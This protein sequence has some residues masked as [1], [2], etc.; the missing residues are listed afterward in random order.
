MKRQSGAVTIFLVLILMA[1]VFFAGVFIDA[2]RILAAKHELKNAAYAAARSTISYYDKNLVGEYGL[3]AYDSSAAQ[4]NF[5]K[6][7][8]ANIKTRDK[9]V[10][11]LNYTVKNITV[12]PGS[13]INDLEVF[14]DQVAEYSKYR[15]PVTTTM[16]VVDK[17]RSIF[18]L[19]DKADKITEAGDDLE[20]FKSKFKNLGHKAS[21]AVSSAAYNITSDVIDWDNISDSKSTIDGLMNNL[22]GSY[23]TAIA[24]MESAKTEANNY[25]QSVEQQMNAV[26]QGAGLGDIQQDADVASDAKEL[27]Q[28]GVV[29]VE[30]YARDEAQKVI[31]DA[32]SKKARAQT[33]K[34]E[35]TN[36][37][38]TYEQKQWELLEARNKYEDA[39]DTTEEK[40]ET[41]NNIKS[42][43][44]LEREIKI[45]EVRKQQLA[46]DITEKQAN[47][48][49][50]EKKKVDEYFNTG[51]YVGDDIF[52]ESETFI[53]VLELIDSLKD[54][55][56]EKN[57][58]VYANTQYNLHKDTAKAEYDVAKA[59]E[60][61]AKQAVEDIENELDS[62]KGQ[63]EG[64]LNEMKGLTISEP[65]EIKEKDA[66][67]GKIDKILEGEGEE[68]E[69]A[70]SKLDEIK[71]SVAGLAEEYNATIEKAQRG[72]E[73]EVD[74]GGWLVSKVKNICNY[75]S[76]MCS[77]FTNGEKLL[78][79]A[80]M[81]DF[82]MDK[83]TFIT[84][85][86]ERD[87]K[88]HVGEV[89]Y[90]IFGHEKQGDN[91]V[92]AVTTITT[93]RFAINFI[94]YF[95]K[96]PGG[97]VSRAVAG[98]TQGAIQTAKDVYDLLFTNDGCQLCPSVKNVKVSYSDHLRLV[99][100]MKF[101]GASEGMLD[102][103]NTNQSY[104]GG[105]S[106]DKLYTKLQ[107]DTE[108][109]IDL[110]FVPLFGGDWLNFPNIKDGQYII[111][112]EAVVGY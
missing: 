70:L 29:E 44:N 55:Q 67:G 65:N 62:L 18:S 25:E 56:K 16:L 59:N 49:E 100:F 57:E 9:G 15:A 11:L 58:L 75:F 1:S 50:E 79:N 80:Y 52:V 108:V 6:Y 40:E 101:S 110:I 86:T 43:G 41:Y 53:E 85:Q 112:T 38:A 97:F 109:G 92:S 76:E 21:D 104:N 4:A 45:L 91:I 82:I 78:E 48:S 105:I 103:I 74:T 8:N 5:E 69:N 95:I 28:D 42:S 106:T 37:M 84:S 13:S 39:K 60:E 54:V 34:N 71:E 20:D 31:N 30:Q 17:F 107:A 111:R 19:G 7:F 83:S 94:N 102:V 22:I 10:N 64:K 89:E 87:H 90:I 81:V 24:N 26:S 36:L 35:V 33:L 14:K 3:Y 51:E 68:G 96:A 23:D 72:D 46:A 66:D 27:E 2:S 99:L 63:I 12:T 61:A 93:L 73:D 32:N 88:F 77:T 47:L 98:L